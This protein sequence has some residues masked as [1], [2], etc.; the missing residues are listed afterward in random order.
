MIGMAGMLAIGR[1]L[2]SREDWWFVQWQISCNTQAWLGTLFNRLAV[3]GPPVC[4]HATCCLMCVVGPV[5][6]KLKMWYICVV[7]WLIMY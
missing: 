3:L 4:C 1:W 5:V 7:M 6:R 2:S